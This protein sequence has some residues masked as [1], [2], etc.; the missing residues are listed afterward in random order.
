M[1]KCKHFV[2]ALAS[3]VFPGLPYTL[4]T[5]SVAHPWRVTRILQK[6]F[7]LQFVNNLSHGGI[8][9]VFIEKSEKK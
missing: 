6:D 5:R 2:A 1:P 7:C 9:P 8:H 4:F 3:Y